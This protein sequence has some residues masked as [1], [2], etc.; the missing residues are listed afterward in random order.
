VNKLA[1]SGDAILSAANLGIGCYQIATSDDQHEK[2]EIFV[3]T[4]SSTVFGG[5]AGFG[6]SILLF[7]NPVGWTIA[8]AAGVGVAASSIAVGKGFKAFY[9]SKSE[10]IDIVNKIGVDQWCN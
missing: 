6:V 8:I 3:E 9:N 5:L 4:V 2:N 1:T 7:S 10:K